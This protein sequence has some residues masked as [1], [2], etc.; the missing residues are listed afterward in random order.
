MSIT[1]TEET[2]KVNLYNSNMLYLCTYSCI[3]NSIAAQKFGGTH[4]RICSWQI[5]VKDTLAA[6]N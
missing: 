6:D 4:T 3:L 2:Y 1:Q 5:K